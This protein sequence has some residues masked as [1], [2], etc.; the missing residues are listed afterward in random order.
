ME[1][2]NKPKLVLV[3]YE[4]IINFKSNFYKIIDF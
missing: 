4:L 1:F 2:N 3:H